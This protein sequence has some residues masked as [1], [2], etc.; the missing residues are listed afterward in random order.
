[1]SWS[2]SVGLVEKSPE[3][4]PQQNDHLH[5]GVEVLDAAIPNGIPRNT[6]VVLHGEG[7]TGKSVF[8]ASI[9]YNRLLAGEPVLFITFDDDPVSLLQLFQSFGW[10]LDEY[11]SKKLFR[12]IDCFTYR[13]KTSGSPPNYVYRVVNPREPN[14]LIEVLSAAMNDMGMNS[15]GAIFIDSLN[16]LLSQSE[17]TSALETVKMIRAVAPKARKVSVYATLHTGIESLHEILFTLEYTVD[18]IIEFRYDPSL[19]QLGMPIKQLQVRKLRGTRHAAISIPYSINSSG[20]KAVDPRKIT[21]LLKSLT[22][23]PK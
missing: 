23:P 21:G 13:V 14:D 4:H 15:K 12:V 19:A 20:I 1:M 8:Q 16:E 10:N 11:I 7:G 17:I 3:F 22:L 9:A 5:T 18:G 6:M 2:T